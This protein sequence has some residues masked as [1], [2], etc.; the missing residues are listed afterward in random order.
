MKPKISSKEPLIWPLVK[1]LFPGADLKKVAFT[2]GQTIYT[3]TSMSFDYIE[4]EKVHMKQQ[5]NKVWGL[6]C[7]IRYALS[8]SYRKKCEIPAFQRQWEALGKTQK[9]RGRIA[10]LMAH[11]IYGPMMSVEEALTYL[12]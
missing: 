6:V 9:H 5:K 11:P 4:H 7:I 8:K 3:Q 10:M 1:W 2:W 12:K